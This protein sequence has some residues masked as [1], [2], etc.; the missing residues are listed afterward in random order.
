VE[1]GQEIGSKS[2]IFGS[3]LIP[4]AG[5]KRGQILVMTGGPRWLGKRKNKE[6]KK[7]RA[8][9]G[10]LVRRHL[11]FTAR[12]GAG[13]GQL[14]GWAGFSPVWYGGRKSFFF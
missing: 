3:D 14:A 10:L 5:W 6:K 13:A 11:L 8:R 4:Y 1:K 2:V 9:A 7:E 12:G